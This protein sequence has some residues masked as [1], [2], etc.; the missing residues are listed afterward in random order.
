M[1]SASGSA[2]VLEALGIPIDLHARPMLSAAL[3]AD[4]FA[5]L[6]A[7]GLPPG[8]E[9]RGADQP[10]AWRAHGVQPDRATD[11]PG[12]RSTAGGRRGR[13]R[14]L[15]RRKSPTCSTDW[16]PSA[17]SSSTATGSTSCRW[18]A[19][20]SSTTFRW[21]AC[22]E[23]RSTRRRWAW[24]SR[25]AARCVEEMRQRTRRSSRAFSTV[26]AAPRRDVVLLNAGAALLVGGRVARLSPRRCDRPPPRSIAVAARALLGRLRERAS[27]RAPHDRRCSAAERRPRDRRATSGR[28]RRRCRTTSREEA[29]SRAAAVAAVA[30]STRPAPHRRGQAPLAVGRLELGRRRHRR[31]C[32]RLRAPGGAAAISVLCEPHWFDG[33]LDDLRAIR[34]AVRVPVLAKDFVVDRV[35][36]PLCARPARTWCCCWP[37]SIVARITGAGE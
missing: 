2:D 23:R 37:C 16:A 7:P 24:Q 13:S 33:S 26:S 4:G 5:F 19:V 18:M 17:P 14:R 10:R 15:P 11:Q 8:D 3:G 34:A 28:S 20:A 25:I 36:W 35:S 31:A 29:P 22:G 12:G 32:A 27:R 30:G 6:F 21:A 9:A 1:S